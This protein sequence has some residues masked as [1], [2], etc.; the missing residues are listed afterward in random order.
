MQKELENETLEGLGRH[1]GC[2][3]VSG[4]DRNGGRKGGLAGKKCAISLTYDD[5]LNTDFHTQNRSETRRP[6]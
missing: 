3:S 4:S 1:S 6:N 2:V 5:A